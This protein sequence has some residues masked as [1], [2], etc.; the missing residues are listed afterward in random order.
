MATGIVWIRP[1]SALARSIEQYG[2]KL[3]VAVK[4]LADYF[5]QKMQDEARRN[6]PWQDRTGNARSGLAGLAE[7]AALD[8]MV[9]YLTHG[10]EYGK[11]LELANGGKYAIVVPTIQ[12]NLPEI[13]RMLQRL[14]A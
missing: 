5:A 4:A 3:R 14:L 1:P 10:V 8:L 7:Q 12:R 13:E 11:W 2:L 6:A 9:I